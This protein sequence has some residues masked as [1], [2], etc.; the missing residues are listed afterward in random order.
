M[1]YL[2]LLPSLTVAATTQSGTATLAWQRFSYPEA[3]FVVAPSAA[4]G[5][6]LLFTGAPAS[7]VLWRGHPGRNAG[8]V[9]SEAMS[10]HPPSNFGRSATRSAGNIESR[11]RF[12]IVDLTSHEV[13]TNEHPFG[14]MLVS[15]TCESDSGSQA[16]TVKIG[17]IILFSVTCTRPRNYGTSDGI[18][19]YT[20]AASMP[21]TTNWG[22]KKT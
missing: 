4:I 12:T 19:G 2:L 17:S 3:T 10:M 7:G 15:A 21:V 5:Q 8:G 14:L 11:R 16:V 18:T 13:F 20:S 6:V 1:E 22:L 9:G